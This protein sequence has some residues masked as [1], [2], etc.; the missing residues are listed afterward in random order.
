MP[1]RREPVALLHKIL[2]VAH[3]VAQKADKAAQNTPI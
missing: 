3:S 1:Y 2:V